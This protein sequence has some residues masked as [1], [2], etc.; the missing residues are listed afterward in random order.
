MAFALLLLLLLFAGSAAAEDGSSGAAAWRVFPRDD[1]FRK[2]LADPKEP[3]FSATYARIDFR[4]GDV[5]AGRAETLIHT[6]MVGLG[7]TVGLWTRRRANGDGVQVSLFGGVFS[8]FDLSISSGDLI[9][10]DFLVGVPVT[11]RRGPWSLRTRLLHQSSHVGDE[12]L[13]RNP[14]IR[15]ENFGFEML[16]TLVSFERGAWR[17][18]GG[19]GVVVNSSTDFDPMAFQ[20]GVEARSGWSPAWSLFGLRPTPVLGIDAK[21]WQ[22]QDWGPTLNAVAG[23]E[24]ARPGDTTRVRFLGTL[25]YG[26][27]PFAQF[28]DDTEVS[29]VG[30]SLQLDL[31]G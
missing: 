2:L 27:Y 17:A 13:L 3:R 1:V 28:F 19:L 18:Y 16:D 23:L 11:V 12:L 20:A 10:T 29:A 15:V 6:G 31:Q 9:N 14:V 7:E 30:L 25:L 8:Q 5:R 26:H 22:Q 4:A 21:T 24:F